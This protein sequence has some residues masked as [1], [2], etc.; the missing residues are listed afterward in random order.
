MADRLSCCVPFCRRTTKRVADQVYIEN[1]FRVDLFAEWICSEHWRH[2]SDRT[3]RLHS[4]AKRRL[5]KFKDL[6]NLKIGARLWARCKR[7]AIERAAG[8]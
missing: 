6:K 4:M 8:I 5:R 2:V 7:E 1:H 3:R